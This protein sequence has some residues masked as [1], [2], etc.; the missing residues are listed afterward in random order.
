MKSVPLAGVLTSG[1]DV[2]QNQ[3]IGQFTD[4]A[5]TSL[6]PLELGPRMQFHGLGNSW[7]QDLGESISG[8]RRGGHSYA[9]NAQGRIEFLRRVYLRSLYGRPTICGQG[10]GCERRWRQYFNRW[11]GPVPVQRSF[12]SK[13]RALQRDSCPLPLGVY[14]LLRPG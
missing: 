4:R 2:A 13:W 14:V 11:S 5:Q 6:S 1:E 8:P 9:E 10:G 7:K 3:G 12:R